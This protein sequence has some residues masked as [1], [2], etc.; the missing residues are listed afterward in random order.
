MAWLSC[1][2]SIVAWE[3]S[4]TESSVL[5]LH[6]CL[7]RD[8]SEFTS[9]YGRL[10]LSTQA[11]NS[12]KTLHAV[13]TNC[14]LGQQ[15]GTGWSTNLGRRHSHGRGLRAPESLNPSSR[16]CQQALRSSGQRSCQNAYVLIFRCLLETLGVPTGKLPLPLLARVRVSRSQTSNY[17]RP[18]FC[19]EYGTF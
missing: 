19:A 10:N 15:H 18:Y 14:H 13:K 2:A 3:A 1:P 17:V 7:S 8:T 6:A 4:E 5:S 9:I 11:Y 16:V 12:K